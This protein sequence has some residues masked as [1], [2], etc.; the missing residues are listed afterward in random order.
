MN[1]LIPSI[2]MEQVLSYNWNFH[3]EK[4]M[5]LNREHVFYFDEV[6]EREIY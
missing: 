5:D 3:V 1:A 4:C 6:F 2:S